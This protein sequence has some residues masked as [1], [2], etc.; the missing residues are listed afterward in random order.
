MSLERLAGQIRR[1]RKC[2]LWK[3]R[4]NAVP[5]EGDPKARLFFVG[6]A[7]GRQEDRRG[8]PFAGAAGKILD[9]SLETACLKRKDVFITSVLKCRPPG[10]RNPRKDE[11]EKCQLHLAS[12]IEEV[13]PD[14]VLA[15]GSFGHKVLS[16]KSMNVSK[17]RLITGEY[18]GRVLM[19]TYHPAAVLYNRRLQRLLTSDLKKAWKLAKSEDVRIISGPTRRGKKTVRLLSAGGTIFRKG[20]ILLIRKRSEKLWG[21]PKGRLEEGESTEEAAR[22]EME[23]ETGL[24]NLRMEK[25][26]CE[27]EY[28]YF[29]PQDDINY[30]KSV[31]YFLARAP[32]N[33]RPRLEDRFDAYIWCTRQDAQKL[34]HHDNDVRTVREAF[35]ALRKK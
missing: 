28:S 35:K 6:E 27:I 32:G 5:G 26:L 12:Q 33:Q 4:E 8:R 13:D 2:R 34:L 29:W 30:Q 14:V 18:A 16:G 15:L 25:K 17:A 7:P 11:I 3:T 1:C 19:A 9:K 22:R 10:N 21:L 24:Q 23:E 31:A 20:R